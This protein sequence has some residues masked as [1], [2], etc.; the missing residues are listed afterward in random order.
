MK[1]PRARG[2]EAADGLFVSAARFAGTILG[3]SKAIMERRRSYLEARLRE[4]MLAEQDASSAVARAEELRGPASREYADAAR[5][6]ERVKTATMGARERLH[7]D[8]FRRAAAL[9]G[10]DVEPHEADAL[11]VLGGLAGFA[12]GV[13]ASWLVFFAMGWNVVGQLPIVF[14]CGAL[15]ALGLYMVVAQYPL[16]MAKRLRLRSLGKSPETVCYMAMSLNLVPSL[17]RAVKFAAEN[18]EEP[19]SSALRKII[20]NVETRQ[21]LSVD[22]SFM[23]FAAEWSGDGEELKMALYSIRGAVSEKSKEGRER[24]LGKATESALSGTRRRIEEFAAG[25][26]GPS[27][28]LFALGILLPLVVGSMLP[29]MAVGTLDVSN[30]GQGL[31]T[32]GDPRATAVVTVLLM[33]VAFPGLAFA[34]AYYVIGRRPGTS[35]PARVTAGKASIV[36]PASIAVL[37]AMLALAIAIGGSEGELLAAALLALGAISIPAGYHLVSIASHARAERKR[38][39]DME[40]EFPDALFQLGRRVAEGVPLEAAFPFVGGR[41]KG[42]EIGQLFIGIGGA[43]GT[44]GLSPERALFDPELGA[45]R[46]IGSRTIRA[47]LRSVVAS[48]E[49][50]PRT[51]GKMMMDFSGYLRDLQKTDHEIRLQL[52]G[53]SE[54]MRNTATL[55][56]PLIMGVTVGLFALLSRTF[57]DVGDG[58]EMMP[59]WLFAGVVGA[60]LMLMVLAISYFCSRLMH[61]DDDVELKWRAGTS[62]ATSWLVFAGAVFVAYTGFA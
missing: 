40:A 15:G 49:M 3:P 51:A 48:A 34:Y 58:V 14:S 47:T 29:M 45:L 23:D 8:R 16:S 26:S 30:L 11:A 1:G 61:G 44:S 52:S 28:I 32:G 24:V 53:I 7:R 6:L 38:M 9:L 12:A 43:M 41:M 42:S 27:T 31:S 33:D 46:Q 62:L 54:N 60:Y 19:L 4:S 59:V 2:S 21:S 39:M 13:L 20:W 22:E 18:G 37:L 56:A 10:L 50:D 57:A 17:E 5:R 36:K 35:S 55:F 25:L